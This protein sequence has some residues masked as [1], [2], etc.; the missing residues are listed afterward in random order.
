V[1]AGL[2]DA[3]FWADVYTAAQP[4]RP[5]DPVVT[6]YGWEHPAR[7]WRVARYIV[8]RGAERIGVAAWDRPE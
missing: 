8:L 4:V 1:S 6:R 5:V 7:L 2:D 3:M